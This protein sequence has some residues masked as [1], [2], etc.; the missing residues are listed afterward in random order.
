MRG[1]WAGRS[2]LKQ[3]KL[4]SAWSLAFGASVGVSPLH[5]I[6]PTTVVVIVGL[7]LCPVKNAASLEN[8][9]SLEGS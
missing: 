3:G 4:E 5:G 1:R 6:S 2:I 9:L 7:G 8:L